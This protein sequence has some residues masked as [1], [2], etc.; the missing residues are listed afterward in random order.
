M[1]DASATTT[2]EILSHT[3]PNNIE[4]PKAYAL[5]LLINAEKVYLQIKEDLVLIFGITKFN[6]YLYRNKFTIVT[7]N[8]PLL[9]LL[10]STILGNKKSI[11]TI[12]ANIL[13]RWAFILSTYSYDIKCVTSN[14]NPVDNL[15]RIF[16][17]YRIK[18]SGSKIN[19]LNFIKEE[20]SWPINWLKIKSSSRID[21]IISKI[22]NYVL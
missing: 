21:S 4:I 3:F 22:I 9:L 8:E 13:Q 7:D 6:D 2:G 11:S 19:Y 1:V 18:D 12:A 5:H 14:N 15:F 16:I 20:S 10:S 17:I